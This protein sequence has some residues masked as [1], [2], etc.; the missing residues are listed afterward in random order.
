MNLVGSGISLVSSVPSIRRRPR[1]R[2]LP[3]ITVSPHLN[4][5]QINASIGTT[6]FWD[7]LVQ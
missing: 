7:R 5:P 4:P 6:D 3:A 1:H 2:A